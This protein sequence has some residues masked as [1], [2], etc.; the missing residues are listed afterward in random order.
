LI[1][2]A[3]VDCEKPSSRWIVGSA[4]FTIVPSSTI[5]STPAHSTYS[6]S[7]R[8]RSWSPPFIIPL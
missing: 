1:T 3:N 5:I 8:S 7:Q 2:H 4:T 6:A